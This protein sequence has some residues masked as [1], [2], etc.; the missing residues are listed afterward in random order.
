VADKKKILI[1][2][3]SA[4]HGHEKAAKA[5]EEVCRSRPELDV[6][7]VDVLKKT[8]FGFGERYRRTYLFTIRA[9]PWF[10]GFGYYLL[11]VR[12][13]YAF[14]KHVRRWNNHFF[15]RGVERLVIAE[16]PDVV[17]STHFLSTETVSHLKKKGLVSSK[18]VTVVTD[19]LAHS[20][21]LASEC[22]HYC[23]AAEDTVQDLM[24]RGVP[25]ERITVTGIPIEA[26][27]SPSLTREAARA[28]LDLDRSRFTA[29]LTSGGGGI[30]LLEP[31]VNRLLIAEPPLQLLVVCGTNEAMRARM[32]AQHREKRGLRL[33]G[34]VNNIHELMAACD[35]VV[36]KGG[37]LTITESL[38]MGRPMVLIGAVPG[39]E[40]KNVR[41]VLKRKA[42][43]LARSISDAAN[44]VRR[45]QKDP[46][47][48]D[49]TRR[50]I[51]LLRRPQ[52][53]QAVM[54]VSV[55]L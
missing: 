34:F 53:A 50:A 4:G 42:A 21:W 22:D 3:A 36:G 16:A 47:L 38:A 35:I 52:A 14:V 5:V 54:D 31:L 33:Y 41:V 8:S 11:D 6:Q 43:K 45:F 40:T 12:A 25:R 55:G 10:W 39:Q 48:Y 19:Y 44:H 24:R 15:A 18:L 46:A 32:D 26:K 49:E 2:Y 29:L 9:L 27:F 7:C 1:L 23:V 20:F 17:V 37:G 30:G 28:K 51:D 13:V